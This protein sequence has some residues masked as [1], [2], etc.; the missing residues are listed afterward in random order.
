[1]EKIIQVTEDMKPEKDWFDRAINIET[2]EQLAKFAKELLIDTQHDY[3]TVCHAI[4]AIALAG[5]HLGAKIQGI[6]SFQ[7]GFV[8]WDFIRQWNY[9]N[10]KCGLRIIDYDNMLYPQYE[11][12]FDK[13]I[14]K[15]KFEAIQ[16]QASILLET[17]KRAHPNVIN[18]W[19]SIID[20]NLPF[21]YSIA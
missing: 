4:G 18:H 7:A 19:K 16:K 13:T 8:M 14:T 12:K 15:E 10:N 21:G 3:G 9:S 17:R 2:P 20:G 5:A 11:A 1:M 6:T